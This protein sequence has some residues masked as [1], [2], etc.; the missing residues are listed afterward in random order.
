VIIDKNGGK[1]GVPG[2]VSFGFSQKG[3]VIVESTTEERLEERL[4]ECALDAGAEDIQGEDGTFRVLCAP[5]DLAAVRS[6]VEAAGIAVDSAEI[7]WIPMQ[8]VEA[9]ADI[10]VQ[11]ERLI[12]ALED[13]DDVQ[14]VYTNLA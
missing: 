13:H 9:D 14:K 12:D 4:M 6:A 5:S 8:T 10:L 11:V 1:I 2:S 3:Q 7:V